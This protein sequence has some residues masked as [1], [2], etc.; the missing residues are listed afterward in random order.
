MQF[1]G[2]KQ[3][4]A[5]ATSERQGFTLAPVEGDIWKAIIGNWLIRRIA[6]AS[7]E[8]NSIFG[9][10]TMESRLIFCLHQATMI[11]ITGS[12]K[13]ERLVWMSA[14]IHYIK[15]GWLESQA[16]YQAVKKP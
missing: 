15:S 7:F 3:I 10:T 11:T 9:D 6:G 4:F 14:H 5:F 1:L 13:T 2:P 16:K 8:L 12:F